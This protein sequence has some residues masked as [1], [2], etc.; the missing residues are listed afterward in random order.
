VMMQ[1]LRAALIA[2]QSATKSPAPPAAAAVPQANMN[3]S[4]VT[5]HPSSQSSPHVINRDCYMVVAND[6]E[7]GATFDLD[8]FVLDDVMMTDEHE[9]VD[10][11][12]L[13]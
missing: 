7:T 5:E 2:S 4:P 8:A 1:T 9:V 6:N 12:L 13:I 11:Q 3:L 10:E